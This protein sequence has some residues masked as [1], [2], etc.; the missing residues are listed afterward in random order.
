MGDGDG[1]EG[2]GAW[3]AGPFAFGAR[4]V[5]EQPGPVLASRAGQGGA[6]PTRRVARGAERGPRARHLLIPARPRRT[7][8]ALR[9]LKDKPRHN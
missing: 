9:L 6:E 1:A 3:S 4:S 8:C 2:W 5:R 7:F